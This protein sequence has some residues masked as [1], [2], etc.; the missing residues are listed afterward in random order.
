MVARRSSV[1]GQKGTTN[2]QR[3]RH[4]SG[5]ATR[6]FPI[7]LGEG[8][9]SPASR[10]NTRG[11]TPAHEGTYTVRCTYSQS[12]AAGRT[13]LAA[14]TVQR[15]PGPELL[16][17]QPRREL[18]VN[19]GNC[20]ESGSIYTAM[21]IALSGYNR[22]VIFSVCRSAPSGTDRRFLIVVPREVLDPL[23]TLRVRELD[24]SA[25]WNSTFQSNG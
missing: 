22:R 11:R 17:A 8:S 13:D 21:T 24:T 10:T 23:Y 5:E 15:S 14:H 4:G 3:A 25:T 1:C 19:H 6:Y 9:D 20:S 7:L 2:T 16:Q 18:R 12:P